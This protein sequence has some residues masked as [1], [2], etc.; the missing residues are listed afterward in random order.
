M[1]REKEITR[2]TLVGSVVNVV[3]TVGKLFAG[4]VGHSAAMIS[5][6]VHSLSDFISDIVVLIFVKIS[7]KGKDENH[8]FGHG[9][10][11]TFGTLLVALLLIIVAVKLLADG[12]SEIIS[13]MHGEIIEP[14][15]MIALW[16]AVVS[17]ISKEILYWYTI[18]V[19]K[20]VDSPVVIANAWHH[21]TDSFSSI[22]SL[23]GIG[24]AILLGEKWTIL[25]PIAGCFISIFIMVAGIN[26]ALPAVRELLDVSLPIE[27]E[28]EIIK[29]ASS[30]QG[31]DNVHELK[32][33]KN[34]PSI[35]IEAHVV[36]NPH[37]TVVEAHDISTAVEDALKEH[38][39]KETQISIHIEPDEE[40]K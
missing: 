8:D 10:F 37:I 30:V 29:V 26:I 34:G 9:K 15:T 20:K 39:G 38:F 22:G 33:H 12:A 6:G 36:V 5:D 28:N 24:G 31:V 14:P 2:V 16:A 32:T 17:I 18:K 35:I 11:E 7:S 21:R 23:L 19:G 3:L 27:M 4:F 40:A 13:L 25:D 1:S